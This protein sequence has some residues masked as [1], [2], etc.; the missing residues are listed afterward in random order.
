MLRGLSLAACFVVAACGAPST[1]C[2]PAGNYD[3][4]WRSASY[5][6]PWNG[7]AAVPAPTPLPLE[8]SG[9]VAFDADG[10]TLSTNLGPAA[11]CVPFTQVRQVGRCH[12]N[13]SCDCS[14]QA[15]CVPVQLYLSWPEDAGIMTGRAVVSVNGTFAQY[16]VSTVPA[17]G[18]P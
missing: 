13:L 11:R 7:D 4:Y 17:G 3:T 16:L 9:T 10:G 18:T 12:F 14:S 8:V 15:G 1:P 5:S 6:P 2:Q